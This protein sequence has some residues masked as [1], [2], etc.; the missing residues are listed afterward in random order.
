MRVP[1]PPHTTPTPTPEARRARDRLVCSAGGACPESCSH[2]R[3]CHPAHHTRPLS[4][5]HSKTFRRWTPPSAGEGPEQGEGA[6]TRDP[7]AH[8]GC[9]PCSLSEGLQGPLCGQL[10]GAGLAVS[11]GDADPGNPGRR[12]WQGQQSAPSAWTAQGQERCW[13]QEMAFSGRTLHRP[14]AHGVTGLCDHSRMGTGP[15]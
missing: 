7:R 9:Q 12:C 13:T 1:G 15:G 10:W 5:A 4:E 11:V 6:V 2:A 8:P 14:R 3:D